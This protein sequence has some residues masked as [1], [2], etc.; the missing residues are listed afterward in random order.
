MKTPETLQIGDKIVK[1]YAYGANV[2][3]SIVAE[4]PTMW[5]LSD[6]ARLRKSDAEEVGRS[7][8]ARTTYWI[9]RDG[10]EDRVRDQM[11]S[12]KMVKD[13]KE[14]DFSNLNKDQLESIVKICK[15]AN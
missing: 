14:F 6:G 8:W 2:M 11:A 3:V 10:E 1:S 12:R 9:P 15:F 13:L 7:Q 4:T 5:K